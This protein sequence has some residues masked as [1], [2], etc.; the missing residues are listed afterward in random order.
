ME[1]QM[2]KISSML[3]DKSNFK[4]KNISDIN[5]TPTR[6]VNRKLE[7][8][9]KIELNNS[10]KTNLVTKEDSKLQRNS[11]MVKKLSFSTIK[12][13]NGLKIT[14]LN[15][16]ENMNTGNI[17][18]SSNRKRRQSTQF[19][20]LNSKLSNLLSNESNTIIASTKPN[21]DELD[22]TKSKKKLTKS[23]VRNF[24]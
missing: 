21:K 18:F 9:N 24:I 2:L 3:E 1:N 8:A 19:L 7:I 6:K 11:V 17:N 13:D 23:N 22:F 20:R 16:N 4:K 5:V 15:M 12:T 14:N 10:D